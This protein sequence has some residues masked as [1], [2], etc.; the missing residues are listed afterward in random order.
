MSIASCQSLRQ[1]VSNFAPS[2]FSHVGLSLLIL[3][4]SSL[5]VAKNKNIEAVNLKQLA[6]QL[7]EDCSPEISPVEQIVFEDS[8]EGSRPS[9]DLLNPDE[10]EAPV[11]MP[12]YQIKLK[13]QCTINDQ[14]LL[15][16]LRAGRK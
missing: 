2:I 7:S 13:G 11:V 1:S 14:S 9:E 10:V 8:G 5:S 15:L 12:A 16:Q 3:L 4:M 6:S